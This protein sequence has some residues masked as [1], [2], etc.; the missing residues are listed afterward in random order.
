MTKVA[1]MT[2]KKERYQQHENEKGVKQQLKET[3]PKEHMKKEPRTVYEESLPNNDTKIKHEI[4]SNDSMVTLPK[5]EDNGIKINNNVP[6]KKPKPRTVVKREKSNSVKKTNDVPSSKQHRDKTNHK[7][8]SGH[9]KS[10]ETKT[11]AEKHDKDITMA[12]NS[13]RVNYINKK[14]LYLFKDK[15]V[16][17]SLRTILGQMQT[18]KSAVPKARFCRIIRQIT[19]EHAQKPIRWTSKARAALQ[20]ATEKFAI[21]LFRKTTYATAHR[22]RVTTNTEDMR[23]ALRLDSGTDQIRHE[24][25]SEML[26]QNKNV[27]ELM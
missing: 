14:S 22:R 1:Q 3:P 21:E 17:A 27:S 15:K 26:S 4:K 8:K 10:S 7:N 9:E 5:P 2:I 11:T 24:Y 23:L 16:R 13:H 12:A 25:I 19:M 6:V 18:K 20:E